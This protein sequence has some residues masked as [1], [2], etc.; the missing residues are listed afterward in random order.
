MKFKVSESPEREQLPQEKILTVCTVRRI[1]FTLLVS[2]L[3]IAGCSIPA[4]A[5]SITLKGDLGRVA[6]TAS[7]TGVA[8]ATRYKDAELAAYT[9]QAND[10]ANKYSKDYT[11][12][13]KYEISYDIVDG[14]PTLDATKSTIKFSMPTFTTLPITLLAVTGD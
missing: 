14:K 13:V 9:K 11:M 5:D 10:Y 8:D 2:F 1:A 6:V 4:D 3:A 7:G 12:F